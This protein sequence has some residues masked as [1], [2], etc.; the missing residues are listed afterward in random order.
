MTNDEWR[1]ANHE[2]LQKFL[3]GTET[4]ESD[5]TGT[6]KA[7]MAQFLS[8]VKRQFNRSRKKTLQY[9]K[10]ANAILQENRL[11]MRKRRKDGCFIILWR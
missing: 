8:N 2:Y 4:D 9:R 7:T 10:H 3:T 11:I 5:I 6:V 1:K